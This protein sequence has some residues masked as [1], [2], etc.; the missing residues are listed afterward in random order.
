VTKVAPSAAV[1]AEGFRPSVGHIT[2]QE[3]NYQINQLSRAAHWTRDTVVLPRGPTYT[4]SQ[5]PSTNAVYRYRQQF[6]GFNLGV[7]DIDNILPNYLVPGDEIGLN[8]SLGFGVCP[9]TIAMI[10]YVD[11]S[12]GTY[13]PGSGASTIDSVQLSGSSY[14][15]APDDTVV[16]ARSDVFSDGETPGTTGQFG[17]PHYTTGVW[18]A[19]NWA[20][21][22]YAGNLKEVAYNEDYPPTWTATARVAPFGSVGD[23]NR[24]WHSGGIM[25][26]YTATPGANGTLVAVG[27]PITGGSWYVNTSTDKG[28]T[29]S[30]RSALSVY[31]P[32]EILLLEYSVALA[33]WVLVDSLGHIWLC[34]GD[35]A[36]GSNW[37]QQDVVNKAFKI[38]PID[39]ISSCVLLDKTFVFAGYQDYTTYWDGLVMITDDYWETVRC[40]HGWSYVAKC[41]QRLGF[42]TLG[43]DS[44]GHLGVSAPITQDSQPN[45]MYTPP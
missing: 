18:V 12:E 17:A 24:E 15:P 38:A 21:S 10:F 28:A 19:E 25:A 40:E 8:G 44:T 7:V 26:H 20:S 6:F 3:A 43:Y 32:S 14:S 23:E 42:C 2:A 37:V 41:G 1:A 4:P 27:Y 30:G 33:G 29:W 45:A 22:G 36:T 39:Y 35:P 11:Y 5:L 9:S 31:T 34:T 13:K 16:C